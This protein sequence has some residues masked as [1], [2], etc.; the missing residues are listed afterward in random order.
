MFKFSN[1]FLLFHYCHSPV[2]DMSPLKTLCEPM[3]ACE[4]MSQPITA[5]LG[6]ANPEDDLEVEDDLK[7]F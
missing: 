4:N 1:Q 2:L 3:T 5:D 6:T 7:H